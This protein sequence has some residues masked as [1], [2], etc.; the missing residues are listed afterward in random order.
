[1]RKKITIS[2]IFVLLVTFV[3][4][5]CS[6]Q[7]KKKGFQIYYLNMDVTKVIPVSYELKAEDTDGKIKEVLE[8]LASD[9]DENDVRRVIPKD[10]SVL[11]YDYNGYLL[12][13]DFSSEYYNMTSTEEVLSRAAIVRSL[14]QISGISYVSFTVGSEH[15]KD[16][17]GNTVSAMSNE[18]FVE[19]PGE[20]INTSLTTTLTLYFA[21][22]D[23]TSLVKEKRSVHYSSNISMEKLVMEQLLEGPK[24]SGMQA[25]VPVETKLITIS[26][27]DGICYVNL[28]EAFKNQNAE[29]SEGV[30]LYSIVDSLTEL[31]NV[32]KV[33][34]SI[35]GD[36]KGKCRYTYELSN[37]Y[38]KDNS[39]VVSDDEDDTEVPR[40][41]SGDS[42]QITTGGES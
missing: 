23:G 12:T 22:S 32:N 38:T 42:T 15:L 10:V 17:D 30:V 29:I 33:Q 27:V 21:S 31:P 24:S 8:A 7:N 41:G 11:G 19:N 25:A 16:A 39:L 13:V 35:N 5:G 34:I 26:V 28:D 9:P 18:S 1:M 37:M 6:G 36:T 14:L 3:F 20:Q 2:L 40:E 4:G